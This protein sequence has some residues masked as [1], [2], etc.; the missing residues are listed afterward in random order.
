M[1]AWPR[2]RVDE[3][4]DTKDTLHM[5]TQVVGKVRMAHAPWVNH[6]WHVTLY[7][8]ARGLTT[9]A[10]PHADGVFEL[11]FD[12][13]EHQLR[14]STSMGRSRTVA[15]EPKTVSAFY[16]ETMEAL[17]A[18]GVET[19]IH[20]V[21]NEVDPAIAFAEDDV[22]RSYDGA[23]AQQFWRQLLQVQRVMNEVR[24]EFYGKASPAHYFWGAMDLAYTRFSGRQAPPHPGGAPNCPISVMREGYSHEL[25]SCG[26]WPGG[27]AEGAFYAYAYPEPPGYPEYAVTPA[28]AR[29]D[30]ALGEFVLP[31]EAVAES[32]DPDAA[33]AS[34]L[35]S[36]FAAA[37]ELGDWSSASK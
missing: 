12:F 16:A 29:Y 18:V 7:P 6:W 30:S 26:F 35:R 37:A 28:E 22:H 19:R 23:A 31:Y 3:W 10:I 36:T 4:A 27:G 9:S 17:R 2:L 33:L 21:P 11:E 5:W 14:I 20:A 1:V 8:S 24:S 13:L 32:S 34:F 15:L 25:A